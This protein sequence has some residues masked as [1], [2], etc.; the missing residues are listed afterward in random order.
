MAN[1][2]VTMSQLDGVSIVALRGEHDLS[3][4]AL[5]QSAL[6]EVVVDGSRVVVDLT[7]A[8]FIDSSTLA[9]L[10]GRRHDRAQVSC[11]VTLVAPPGTGPRRLLDL[12]QAGDHIRIFAVR[13]LALAALPSA[14]S[15]SSPALTT[16]GVGRRERP[17][18]TAGHSSGGASKSRRRVLTPPGRGW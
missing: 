6:D 5:L 15:S 1:P 7:E 14:R 16:P 4:S 12:V 9:T 3:T 18:P 11:A 2:S 10:L 8:T 13:D 17:G